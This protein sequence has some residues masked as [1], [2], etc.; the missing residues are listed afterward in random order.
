MDDQWTSVLV[1]LAAIRRAAQFA[2]AVELRQRLE[3]VASD[4]CAHGRAS[5]HEGRARAVRKQQRRQLQLQ[6]LGQ[7]VTAGP[8]ARPTRRRGVNLARKDTV[9]PDAEEQRHHPDAVPR[10]ARR[11]AM[12]CHNVIH[13]DHAMMLR[14]DVGD[15]RRHQSPTRELPS[16]KG[17]CHDQARGRYSRGWRCR[18][19]RSADRAQERAR[20]QLR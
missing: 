10:L 7:R 16:R 3:L 9:R 8:G 4:P 15:D 19:W 20:R 11:Y 5:G 14:F 13:E 18:R 12:H 17:D 1:Q 6:S 2:R